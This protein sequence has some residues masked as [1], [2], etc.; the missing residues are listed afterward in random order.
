MDMDMELATELEIAKLH[1]NTKPGYCKICHTKNQSDFYKGKKTICKKCWAKQIAANYQEKHK[2]DPVKE[3][4]DKKETLASIAESISSMAESL[5]QKDDLVNILQKQI[6]EQNN[7]IK[8]QSV[9]I[10]KQTD[11]I[12]QLTEE[13][14]ILT[15]KTTTIQNIQ[16]EIADELGDIKDTIPCDN[17]LAE[18]QVKRI[19]DILKSLVTRDYTAA[20]LR[21]FGDE[22]QLEI[23]KSSSASK[24]KIRQKLING[25]EDILKSAK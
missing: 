22:F 7:L 8:H 20:E 13:V 4:Q 17:F 25:L 23:P 15:E 19:K 9:Q 14:K 24:D 18:L 1:G 6:T 5:K 11:L 12:K 2:D 16:D 10:A 21:A 3:K